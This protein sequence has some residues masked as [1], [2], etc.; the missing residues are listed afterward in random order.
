LSLVSLKQTN[1]SFW[2]LGLP[3]PPPC[4]VLPYLT[5]TIEPGRI[6]PKMEN[7]SNSNIRREDAQPWVLRHVSYEARI[8]RR[9]EGCARVS[10]LELG[11][12]RSNQLLEHRRLPFVRSSHSGAIHYIYP[13]SQSD[14]YF[15]FPETRESTDAIN[16]RSRPSHWETAVAASRSSLRDTCMKLYF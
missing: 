11:Q 6:V 16:N 10:N 9:E 5:A 3:I 7:N 2:P 14:R 8:A 15:L 4:R 12:D 1:R 13:T